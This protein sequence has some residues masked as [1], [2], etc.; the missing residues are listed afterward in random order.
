MKTTFVALL[1]IAGLALF[2]FPSIGGSI[3]TSEAGVTWKAGVNGVA[4]ESGAD[5]NVNRI[6]SEYSQPVSFPDRRG[7]SRA[8]VIAEEKAKAAII[9]FLEGEGISQ[10]RTI[11]MVD[12]ETEGAIREVGDAGERFSRE[13]QRNFMESLTE[14]TRS[15]AK[16]ELRGVIVL[17]K[18]YN[19]DRE[20]AWVK[21]GISRKTLA[22]ASSMKAM[23]ADDNP[24]APAE[25]PSKPA[26]GPSTVTHQPSEVTTSESDD[27]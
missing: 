23:I 3:I 17:E 13:S 20:E 16:G 27:W 19:E 4:I 2:P 11:A 8:Q 9:R 14:I 18:G 15:Y 6:Y 26:K 5:G 22:A 1:A 25:A 10:E 24:Q 21:V 12:A 7:I